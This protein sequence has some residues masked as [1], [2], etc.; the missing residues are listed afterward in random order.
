MTIQIAPPIL[1]SSAPASVPSLIGWKAGKGTT[2]GVERRNTW[3]TH[4]SASH[5]RDPS[6]RNFIKTTTN[7]PKRTAD[8]VE[9][10]GNK[11]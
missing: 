11:Y 1:N 6:W 7:K 10:L 3:N 9:A 2:S 5:K 4:A 8:Q